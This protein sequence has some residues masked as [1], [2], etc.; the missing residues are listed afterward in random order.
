MLQACIFDTY[1]RYDPGD[2]HIRQTIGLTD[3]GY[4]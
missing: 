2:I 1:M 4:G 3:W